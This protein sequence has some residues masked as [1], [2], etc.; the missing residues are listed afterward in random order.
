MP[1]HG[2]RLSPSILVDEEITPVY[3]SKNY[4][5]VKPGEI[6]AN[7]YQTLVKVDWGVSSTVWLARDLQGYPLI[8]STQF[9]ALS[10]S[11]KRT[12]ISRN[13]KLPWC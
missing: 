10:V 13:Q 9:E 12:G 11:D 5:A 7:R 6:L 3:N 2:P 8:S 4:Y 1:L